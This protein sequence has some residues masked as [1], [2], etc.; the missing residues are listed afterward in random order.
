M[1]IADLLC[2]RSLR[3][4]A[5]AAVLGVWPGTHLLV[6]KG[7]ILRFVGIWVAWAACVVLRALRLAP[8]IA[9]VPASSVVLVRFR[10]VDSPLEISVKRSEMHQR[11][12]AVEEQNIGLEAL[13]SEVV[14]NISQSNNL[15][16]IKKF[17]KIEK[18]ENFQFFFKNLPS[19]MTKCVGDASTEHI[20]V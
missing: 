13:I 8:L 6:P 2:Q 1:L 14:R 10:A 18:F 16:K 11:L 15:P 12:I 3:F 5:V 4:V 17:K 20:I 7:T 19:Y 9:S